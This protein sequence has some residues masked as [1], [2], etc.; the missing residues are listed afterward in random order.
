MKPSQHALTILVTGTASDSHTWNLV[1]LQLLL[2]EQGHHVVPLGPCVGDELLVVECLAC[3][4]D[5]VVISSVN[6]HGYRDG[7][8]AVKRLRREHRLADVP[9]VIG[10]KLGIE[11]QPDAD[12]ASRLLRAGCT[13]VF[14]GGEGD[15]NAFRIFVEQLPRRSR[16]VLAGGPSS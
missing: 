12:A 8:S 16:V 15:A 9:V 10:G 6:G 13:A 3:V 14:D 7:L 5:L 11:G 4:P 1:Y 2:Q